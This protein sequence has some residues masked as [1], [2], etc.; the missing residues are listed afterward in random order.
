MRKEIHKNYLKI[1]SNSHL[2]S[3]DTIMLNRDLSYTEN[4]VHCIAMMHTCKAISSVVSHA[5]TLRA[6]KIFIVWKVY[7][8]FAIVLIWGVLISVYLYYKCIII[9]VS[10]I[11]GLLFKALWMKNYL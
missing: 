6:C 4:I 7:L 10:I 2:R 5:L 3:H 11:K 8:L 1:H 9:S